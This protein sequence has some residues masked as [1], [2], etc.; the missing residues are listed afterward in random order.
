MP[1]GRLISF[2][3]GMQ[4]LTQ[5]LAGSSASSRDQRSVLRALERLRPTVVHSSVPEQVT[6]RV[7]R[8]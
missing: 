1:V 5:T 8:G 4:T 2:R 6:R 7:L 3:D